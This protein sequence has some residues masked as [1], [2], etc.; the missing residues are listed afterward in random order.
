MLVFIAELIGTFLL[1]LIGEA[2]VA[3]VCL[4]KS[5]MKGAGSIQITLAWGFAVMIPAFIFGVASGAHFNPALTIALAADGTIKWSIVPQ[6]LAGQFLGAFLGAAL[7]ALMFNDQF[8]ATDDQATKLGVFCTS[9]SVP[10]TLLNLLSE[11]VE[12][13]ILVFAIKGIGNVTSIAPGVDK[14]MVFGIIVSIGMS[15]GGLTGYAINPARDFAPR[16]A[17]QLL[18]IPGKGE[19]NW[20]YAW[21]P[22]V[23]P[24]I[25][26]LLA[27]GLFAIIPW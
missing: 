15:F 2:V 12:T 9:P 4:N 3:N 6:Y 10:N 20:G 7:V 18:P 19:S 22:V 5:G 21:I 24:V 26:A 16:L 11:I 13:F 8:K 25:G 14:F 23:G 17:H 27:V 1:I